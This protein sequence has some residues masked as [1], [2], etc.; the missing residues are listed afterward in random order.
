MVEL[1]FGIWAAWKI[2]GGT[3]VLYDVAED[4]ISYLIICIFVL[5]IILLVWIRSDLDWLVRVGSRIGS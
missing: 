4:C 2:D 1:H 3:D 5:I